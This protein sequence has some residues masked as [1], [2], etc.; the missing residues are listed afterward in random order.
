MENLTDTNSNLEV[1]DGAQMPSSVSAVDEVLQFRC[2]SCMKLYQTAFSSIREENPKFDCKQC[3]TRFF[4]DYSHFIP[5]LEL[6]GRL[7]SEAQRTLKEQVTPAEP[8][9]EEV[10]PREPCP[11]CETPILTSE[12]ECPA[13]GLMVEKYKK[14]LSDPTSY[15]KGSRQL[16]DLRMAVLAHYQD[17]D[18]HEELI[19]QA[20]QEDNLEFAAKFYGRLVR[21]HPNDDIAPKY[22][23]RIAGLSMIKTDMAATEKRVDS[24]PKRRRVR[25]VPMILCIGCA[26]VGIG[27]GVPQ[28]KN[29]V[30]IGAAMSF[31]ALAFHFSFSPKK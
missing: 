29:L 20:Q 5:G 17:E 2:P 22:V 15:I 21:L 8:V 11:K 24:K 1:M 7:E 19:R 9:A 28:M 6:L 31:L 18:L 4:L 27:L 23:Q 13:C 25:I 14:M 10:V 12:E 30:G 26:L 3:S 16:E